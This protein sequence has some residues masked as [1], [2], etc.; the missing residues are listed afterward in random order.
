MATSGGP[1]IPTDGL[2]LHLDA[3][4]HRCISSL[5]NNSFSGAEELAKNLISPTDII[6]SV[7]GVNIGNLNFY[8]AFAIDYPEG[9][10]GGDAAGRHGIT[11]GL[12]VR[13]GTKLYG[14]SRALHLWVYNNDTN[15][16]LP[17]SF[18]NG[19]LLNG[20]CYDSW[21]GNSTRGGGSLVQVAQFVTDY[22][23]IKSQFPNATYIAMGS[24]RDSRHTTDKINALLD[25][26]A[27]SNVSSLLGG[28]PEWILVGKPGLGTDNAYGWAYEN[29]PVDPT[30]VAHLNFGLPIYGNAGNYF[31]FDGINDA[32]NIADTN[33]LRLAGDKSLCLWVRMGADSAGCGIAGKSNSTVRGMAIGYGWNGNGFMALA[34]NSSNSPFIT[35]DLT[36]DIANWIYLAAV[37]NGSTRHIYAID[38]QGVRTSTGTFGTHTWDNSVPLTIGNANN[39]GNPAPSGTRIA[40]TAVYNRA[41]SAEEVLQNFNATKNRFGL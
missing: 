5:G 37:Q 20:H 38:N 30:R 11:P 18:F 35:K 27:P 15:S 41:L 22:N 32:I 23:N 7:N 3:A 4:N 17:S 1:K 6:Q 21:T 19:A 28:A 24:H 13:S 39:G 36:R 2:V 31:E 14:A 8:T 25:L 26:G 16:W 34:W 33:K 12:D 10:F 9:S 29:F 40:S